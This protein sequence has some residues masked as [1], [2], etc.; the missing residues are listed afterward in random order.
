ME[1]LRFAYG[2]PKET[3]TIIM[4]LYKNMK[5]LL[6]WQRILQGDELF[7]CT[8]P[9]LCTWNIKKSNKRKWFHIKKK[10]RQYPTESMIDEGY[11]NNLALLAKRPA[12][13]ESLLHILEQAVGGISLYVNANKT[14]Y[15]YF[16]QDSKISGPVHQHLIYQKRC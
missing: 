15:I 14:E 5:G 6:T 12:Q 9:R 13:A 11:A 8:L 16:K 10:K 1:Q 3:V 2:F 7:V 4:M